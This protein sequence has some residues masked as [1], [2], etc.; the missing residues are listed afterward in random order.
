MPLTPDEYTA[1]ARYLPKEVLAQFG[2]PNYPKVPTSISVSAVTRRTFANIANQYK[3]AGISA[4]VEAIG[5]GILWVVL[6]TPEERQDRL[7]RPDDYPYIID[8]PRDVE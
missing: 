3:Y 1:L 4:V 8:R 7:E 6:P 2:A 5:T